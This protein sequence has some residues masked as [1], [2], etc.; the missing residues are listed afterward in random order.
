[1]VLAVVAALEEVG[2]RRFREEL[3]AEAGQ[4]SCCVKG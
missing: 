2:A 3:V 4:A 1:M